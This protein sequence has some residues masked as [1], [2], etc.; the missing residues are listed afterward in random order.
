MSPMPRR[1]FLC[2]A[3]V[4]L[5]HCA[6]KHQP[7]VFEPYF[8]S[9][10]EGDFSPEYLEESHRL[11]AKTQLSAFEQKRL[12][13]L[14]AQELRTLKPGCSR[15]LTL[16]ETMQK[17]LP[18]VAPLQKEAAELRDEVRQYKDIQPPGP[19][20]TKLT[21]EN[22]VL[23]KRYSEIY[24]LWNRDQ[25]ET[26]FAKLGELMQS[27][28]FKQANSRER[29]KITYLAF[30]IDLDVGDVAASEAAYRQLQELDRCGEITAQSGLLVAIEAMTRGD[31]KRAL[32]IFKAQC[33][34]DDSPVHRIQLEYWEARFTESAGR[35]AVPLYAKA[36]SSHLPSYYVYL[37]KRHQAD[38]VT[39]L[40]VA[41]P[42]RLYLSQ[43][44]LLPG[45]VHRLLNSA[46]LRLQAN[47][48]KDSDLYLRKAAQTLKGDLRPQNLLPLLYI[49]HLYQ[50]AGD[51]LEAMK[52]YA[53]VTTT[54]EETPLL[55][56]IDNPEF[57][58]EMFPRPFSPTVEWL[59]HEWKLDPDFTYAIMRQ[60][61]AFNPG[62]ISVAHARGLMQ[63]LPSVAKSLS[64][65]WGYQTFY[66][67]RMLFHASENL[68]LASFF[69]YRL[70]A[71]APHLILKAAAYNAGINRVNGWWKKFGTLPMDAFVEFIPASETRNYVKLVLRNFIYYKALRNG[72]TVDSTLVPLILPPFPGG[73]TKVST[74]KSHPSKIPQSGFNS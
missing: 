19:A 6:S 72:G 37:A 66:S 21:L 27:S 35:N 56:Q 2:L 51:H 43:E 44:L 55:A 47:L 52:L 42:G 12:W 39:L 17:L 71:L 63:L 62:A 48:R 53:L 46:E 26:A 64:R 57:L 74:L 31:G 24:H 67:D 20:P 73:A 33:D 9:S 69:L 68:K 38:Q 45:E 22:P 3:M 50:A 61:S 28:E 34:N 13:D 49:A 7:V 15:S 40:P 1:L 5:S 59:A 32:E 11:E 29:F 70:E 54:F 23:K 36:A 10:P 14:Y 16:S 41:P 4:L 65:Q 18:E 58:T 30:R 8:P 25:N 60:E